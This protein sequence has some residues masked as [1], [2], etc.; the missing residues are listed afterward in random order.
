MTVLMPRMPPAAWLRARFRV[1]CRVWAYLF[2]A[3]VSLI[4][5]QYVISICLSA[6]CVVS[7]ASGTVS[8]TNHYTVVQC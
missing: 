2:R 7:A 6:L 1:Q 3:G 5:S 4:P 8:C